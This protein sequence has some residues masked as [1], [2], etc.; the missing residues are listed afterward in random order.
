MNKFN[1]KNF[2]ITITAIALIV[3]GYLLFSAI[4]TWHE[5]KEIRD[6]A[7]YLVIKDN[8]GN[9]YTTESAIGTMT[10]DYEREA[11]PDDPSSANR[12]T[13]SAEIY[14]KYKEGR[15]DRKFAKYLF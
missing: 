8:K 4:Y 9:E 12:L 10:L 2:L 5:E 15:P 13:F 11:N 6:K 7:V 3:G 1:L 14:F